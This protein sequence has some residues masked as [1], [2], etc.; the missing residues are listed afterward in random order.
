MNYNDNQGR[1]KTKL[2]N[3]QKIMDWIFFGIMIYIIILL[4]YKIISLI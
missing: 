2:E 3:D 1:S 4:I